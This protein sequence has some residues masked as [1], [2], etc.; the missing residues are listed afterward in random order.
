MTCIFQSA[1]ENWLLVILCFW[2]CFLMFM[3]R[4]QANDDVEEKADVTVVMTPTTIISAL[5]ELSWRSPPVM[6]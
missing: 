2:L 3:T 4:R 1:P 5:P 6:R